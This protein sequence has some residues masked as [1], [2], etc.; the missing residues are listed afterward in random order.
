MA[1]AD[2]NGIVSI[3]N[4]DLVSPLP[5]LINQIPA[6]V[7]SALNLNLRTFLVA[8]AAARD[9][10]ATQRVPSLA[11]PL[12]VWRTDTGRF[13][14]NEGGG[15]QNWPQSDVVIPGPN[16]IVINGTTYQ[17]TGEFASVPKPTLT[18]KSPVAYATFNLARPYAPPTGWGFA[19]HILR[20][21]RMPSIAV[22]NPTAS[23]LQARWSQFGSNTW[24]ANTR[25]GWTLVKTK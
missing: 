3:Q 15:W 16:D 6:S 11:N 10:L 12:L 5:A 22:A 2:S 1:I 9:T 21:A 4:S 19:L 14:L 17:R 23:P 20:T 18:W 24:D 13:E 7:S 8:G 25:I